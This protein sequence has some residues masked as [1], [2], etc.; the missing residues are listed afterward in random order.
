MLRVLLVEDNPRNAKWVEEALRLSGI[1]SH[2]VLA[3]D[4]EQAMNY[5]KSLTFD[6]VVMNFRLAFPNALANLPQYTTERG[7]PP[8]VVYDGSGR[9]WEK[10]LVSICGAKGYMAG[11]SS[12]KA[13]ASTIRKTIGES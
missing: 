10:E 4:T 13:F 1:S 5:V 7:A 8:V 11:A 3:C 2:V 9:E 12:I 6:L